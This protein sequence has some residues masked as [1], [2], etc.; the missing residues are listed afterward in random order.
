MESLSLRDKVQEGGFEAKLNVMAHRQGLI[1]LKA[2]YKGT[3]ISLLVDSGA[4]NSFVSE[5][6]AKRLEL[7]LSPTA[8]P[9]KVAFAQGCQVQEWRPRF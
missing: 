9:I 6:S 3:N 2:K 4:T 8:K 7:E 1:Y 5:R